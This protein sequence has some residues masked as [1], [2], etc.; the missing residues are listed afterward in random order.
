MVTMTMMTT[1]RI[2]GNGHRRRAI[3]LLGLAL[4]QKLR[5]KLIQICKSNASTFSMSL[6]V[7]QKELL[8][9]RR[10]HAIGWGLTGTLSETN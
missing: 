5:E 3:R 2:Q 7:K 1:K 10:P 9:L 8:E 6:N 4:T